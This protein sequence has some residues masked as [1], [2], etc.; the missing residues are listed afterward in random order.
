MAIAMNRFFFFVRT[1]MESSGH[2]L[3][4]RFI[5]F[6][7]AIWFDGICTTVKVVR[8]GTQVSGT[9]HMRNFFRFAS[10][11]SVSIQLGID[12]GNIVLNSHRMRVCIV[13]L[14]RWA[15]TRLELSLNFDHS[16]TNRSTRYGVLRT[17]CDSYSFNQAP[18]VILSD[19][20]HLDF[21]CPK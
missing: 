1:S 19:Q 4:L 10:V 20:S 9:S 21:N 5:S 7:S 3:D 2:Y 11:V 13:A 6:Q 14:G 15:E 12:L 16:S 18:L 17:K 8:N